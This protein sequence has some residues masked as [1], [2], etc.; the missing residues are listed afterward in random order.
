MAE[1]QTEL[2]EIIV[3]MQYTKEAF[4]PVADFSRDRLITKDDAFSIGRS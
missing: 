2:E 3:K 4:N 1:Q